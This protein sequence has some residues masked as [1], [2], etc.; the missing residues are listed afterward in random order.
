MPVSKCIISLARHV[1]HFSE[2][3]RHWLNAA[4]A[5]HK[6]TFLLYKY[7]QEQN[8]TKAGQIPS[9]KY[10]HRFMLK[11]EFFL[12]ETNAAGGLGGR[13][14]PPNGGLRGRSKIFTKIFIQD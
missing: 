11:I 2:L 14:E 1:F 6:V 13:C 4:N 5:P 9:T 10:Y 3:I 12:G 8:D 7:I